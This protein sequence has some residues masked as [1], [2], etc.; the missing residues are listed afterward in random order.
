VS[1]LPLAGRTVLVTGARAGIGR[2]VALAASSAGADVVLAFPGVADAGAVV[3][4]VRARGGGASAVECDVG[5]ATAVAAAVD[6]AVD[7]FGHLDVVVHNATSRR[8]GEP[9]DLATVDLDTW[10]EHARV[11]LRGAYHCA[12][13]AHDELR[14]RQG[15]L[16]LLTSPAGCEGIDFLGPYSA[17]K[18]GQRAMVK[19]LAREW[20]PEGIRVNA[21]MPLAWTPAMEQ[22]WAANPPLRENMLAMVPLG[23]MGDPET[24]I[25]PAV[26]F[27]A[28][29]GARY[30]TG[31]TIACNGGRFTSL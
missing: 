18:G 11:S 19:A 7:R 16:V 23:W 30:V 27:L 6:H 26:V 4:E 15:S 9:S 14:R 3:D 5:D 21:V 22:A 1:A 31:Q 17:V 10:E 29:E 2:G 20:G 28:G 12:V 13:A 24:D 8:S 25:A